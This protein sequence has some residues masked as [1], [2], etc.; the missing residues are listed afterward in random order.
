MPKKEHIYIYVNT[1]E[2][3]YARVFMSC[4]IV[5]KIQI[6]SG[7]P[8]L[9]TFCWTIICAY[10]LGLYHFYEQFTSAQLLGW[11]G[12]FYKSLGGAGPKALM[13]KRPALVKMANAG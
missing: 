4:G 8:I 10:C 2:Y 3:N 11:T 13:L 12:T 6:T 9:G 7:G 1:H 5:N